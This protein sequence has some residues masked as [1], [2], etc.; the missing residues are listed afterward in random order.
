MGERE[1]K[2]LLPTGP[3]AELGQR[4]WNRDEGGLGGSGP[5][6][7][8]CQDSVAED[9]GQRPEACKYWECGGISKDA[10]SQNRGR[11]GSSEEQKAE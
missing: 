10:G 7:S 6:W 3:D 4:D 8:C 5:S 11:M 1:R 9:S 2:V